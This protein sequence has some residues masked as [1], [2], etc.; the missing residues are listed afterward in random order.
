MNIENN[1]TNTNTNINTNTNTNTNNDYFSNIIGYQEVKDELVSVLNWINN[2]DAYIKDNPNVIFPKGFLFHGPYGCGKTLFMREFSKALN[3]KIFEIKGSG[4]AS[5]E[6]EDVFTKARSYVIDKNDS[7]DLKLY[8]KVVIV[9]DE[10]DLLISDTK[11]ERQLITQMDGFNDEGDIVVLATTNSLYDISDALLRSGRFDRE[12]SIKVPRKKDIPV[13]LNKFLS[14]LDVPKEELE[15]IDLEFLS[16]LFVGKSCIDIKTIINDCYLRF[17]KKFTTDNLEQSYFFISFNKTFKYDKNSSEDN[18]FIACHEAA[19][20]LLMYYYRNYFDFYRACIFNNIYSAGQA[21]SFEDLSNICCLEKR[22]ASI[23]I[24]LAGYIG[25][26][27]L[28][29][30][31]DDGAYSDL[32]KARYESRL[33]VNSFGYLGPDKILRNFDR[34]S[35]NECDEFVYRNDKLSYRLLK[36][37]IRFVTKYIKKNKEKLRLITN[38]IYEDGYI[39]KVSLYDIMESNN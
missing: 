28:L 29:G 34:N 7:Q 30:Y 9:I 33:L 23:D 15:K 19:H 24:A 16:K 25:L 8:E 6:I 21:S 4:D 5:K 14:D 37:R 32:K 18:Y 17:D 1:K 2:K 36:K 13:F 11:A 35:R 39:N 20:A 31:M 22:V 38:K 26:K 10:V 12:I 27:T 3:R